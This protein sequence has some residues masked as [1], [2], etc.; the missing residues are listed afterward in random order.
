[1]YLRISSLQHLLDHL[2]NLNLPSMHFSE[3]HICVYNV[4]FGYFSLLERMLVINILE[5]LF[6]FN[7]Y[8]FFS[9][10]N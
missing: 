8:N 6:S 1:M 9:N 10:I 3:L 5:I 4:H 7:K 2:Y